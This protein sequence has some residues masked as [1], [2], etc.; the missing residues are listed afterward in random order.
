LNLLVEKMLD[1]TKWTKWNT[2]AGKVLGDSNQVIEPAAAAVDE[3][4][5]ERLSE[6]AAV[7]FNLP[8]IAEG[9]DSEG[10]EGAD[11][12]DS[13]GEE[14]RPLHLQQESSGRSCV[15]QDV[16]AISDFPQVCKQSSAAFTLSLDLR[17]MYFMYFIFNLP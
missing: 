13:E 2:N 17:F 3:R 9:S 4:V 12:S 14:D 16:V 15:K 8:A 7:P 10:E 6:A 1:R 11:C 5:D